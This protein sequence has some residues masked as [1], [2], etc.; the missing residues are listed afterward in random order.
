MPKHAHLA[1]LLAVAAA[2]YIARDLA[3]QAA[4]AV[5]RPELVCI[6]VNDT[7]EKGILVYWEEKRGFI[8]TPLRPI[9]WAKQYFEKYHIKGLLEKNTV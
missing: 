7:I 1:D 9:H 5:F 2:G 8:L 4:T 6:I 3:G